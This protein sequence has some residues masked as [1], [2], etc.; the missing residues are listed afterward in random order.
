MNKDLLSIR[1][2][3]FDNQLLL[4][5]DKTKLVIFGSRQMTAKVSDFRLFLL[6]KEL[7]PVK[8]ARDLA[9]TL[10]SNL[11]Y[12]EHIV[13]TVSSCMSRLGQINR[14]KHIFNKHAL[15]IIINAL[16]F[17]KLF[18]CSSVWSN[19]TQTNLDKL[20]AVQN[21][22]CRILSGAKKFDH[23]TPLLKDLRWL[24]IRQQLYFRFAVLV[25]KCMTSCAPEYL[26]SKLVGRSAVSTRNTR[27]SQLLN[28]PLFRTASGQR[29]FQYR[30]TSLWNELQPALKLSP[31]VTEFKCLL[32][33]KLLNDCFI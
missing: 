31:S 1:N 18:Y 29:T 16:V 14:V 13:S 21:F 32:R 22:A 26:T 15:I 2:W 28:I 24:P 23:I 33:Q 12:N 25:F 30:A 19:T 17:S 3:C 10:D 4:N 7:E 11:T 5:P 27:N 8:A 6:G 9:V 20:Q